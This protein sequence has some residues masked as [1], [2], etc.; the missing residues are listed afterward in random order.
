MCASFQQ[1]F[2]L[3]VYAKRMHDTKCAHDNDSGFCFLW[4]KFCTQFHSAKLEKRNVTFRAFYGKKTKRAQHISWSTCTIIIK[5]FKTFIKMNESNH[6]ENYAYYVII[7]LKLNSIKSNICI[8][9]VK[10]RCNFVN[11]IFSGT[12][13]C[14]LHCDELQF[15]VTSRQQMIV[16]LYN[17]HSL[18]LNVFVPFLYFICN[19]SVK[20][21]TF[22]MQL[23][24]FENY[25][26]VTY[27]NEIKATITFH[28]NSHFN[29]K[30]RFFYIG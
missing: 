29:K 13:T 2:L 17:C 25:L 21:N 14:C 3:Y 30:K 10:T 5:T 15:N 1:L 16:Q 7:W 20:I 11:Q 23:V 12:F 8:F 18:D 27:N 26:I 19:N 9:V 28:T 6:C 22:N 24:C 4:I